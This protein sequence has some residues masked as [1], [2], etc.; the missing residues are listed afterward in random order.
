MK[1]L[2][3]A[4]LKAGID[5]LDRV[6]TYEWGSA[7]VAKREALKL[8]FIRESSKA[9]IDGPSDAIDLL[10]RLKRE[11]WEELLELNKY[12]YYPRPNRLHDLANVAHGVIKSMLDHQTDKAWKESKGRA[13]ESVATT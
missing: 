4:Q 6:C 3:S 12:V 8:R 7:L 10:A 13:E 2:T 1:T 5:R 11:L 9:L